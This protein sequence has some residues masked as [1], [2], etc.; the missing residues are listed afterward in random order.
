MHEMCTLDNYSQYLKKVIRDCL[1]TRAHYVEQVESYCED[2]GDDDDFLFQEK[3]ENKFSKF[4]EK[5]SIEEQK[6]SSNH[7]EK[8]LEHTVKIVRMP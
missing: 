2:E 7:M 8:K 1:A 3:Y 4:C 6:I 5:T